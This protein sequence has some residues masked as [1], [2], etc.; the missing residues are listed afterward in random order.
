MFATKFE[1]AR[2][3]SLP[4][5]PHML[6]VDRKG[7]HSL[8]GLKESAVVDSLCFGA[9][10]SS[11]L[12]DATLIAAIEAWMVNKGQHH[13]FSLGQQKNIRRHRKEAIDQ[14]Q[15]R[16]QQPLDHVFPRS[17]QPSCYLS[18]VSR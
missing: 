6:V 5:F 8:K 4:P 12:V 18:A 11:S 3:S 1:L 15:L 13:T 2:S 9:M 14:D 16:R 17:Q 10:T 7:D